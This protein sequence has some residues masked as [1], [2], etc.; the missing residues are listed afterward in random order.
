MGIKR[1]VLGR[2]FQKCKL[3]LVKNAYKR[4]YLKKL[5]IL[6]LSPLRKEENRFFE[7]TFFRCILSLR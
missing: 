6:G 7:I 4:S 5:K 2:S 1:F 3:T